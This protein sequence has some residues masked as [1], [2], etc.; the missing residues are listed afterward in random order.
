MSARERWDSTCLL[1]LSASLAFNNRAA[2]TA[3][4]VEHVGT[5]DD[6][7][8]DFADALASLAAASVQ[9]KAAAA[10]ISKPLITPKWSV[11]ST[12]RKR[13]AMQMVVMVANND[14]AAAQ[15]VL[16]AVQE[17]NDVAEFCGDLTVLAMRAFAGD[18]G[19]VR[20]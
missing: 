3:W 16:G 4:I 6:A 15:G 14:R 18:L 13:L 11:G 8:L 12:H 2:L 5:D 9:L 10:G 7:W 17:A 19:K 1:A 20:R